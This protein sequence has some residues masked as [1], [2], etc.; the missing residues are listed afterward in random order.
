MVYPPLRT[1]M[2]WSSRILSLIFLSAVAYSAPAPDIAGNWLGTLQIEK[3][4]LRIQFRIN[5]TPEKMLVA[6]MDSLDQGL[7]DIPVEKV[8][9]NDN[10]VLLDVKFI[11][12]RFEGA[13]DS[14]GDSMA[15]T[16]LQGG[17]KVPLTL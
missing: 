8:I 3:T 7:R 6:T 12:G 14:T 11:E 9:L 17:Q 5:K 13:V 15:G 1:W 10:K 16:W 4:K 2:K